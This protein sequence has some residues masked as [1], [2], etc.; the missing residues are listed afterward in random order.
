MA[1]IQS[2]F[3]FQGLGSASVDTVGNPVLCKPEDSKLQPILPT[4][5]LCIVLK[6]RLLLHFQMVEQNQKNQSITTHENCTKFRFQCPCMELYRNT[7]ML[8]CLDAVCGCFPHYSRRVE[9]LQHTDQSGLLYSKFQALVST[10]L[11]PFC[12]Q[13]LLSNMPHFPSQ[14][15]VCLVFELFSVSA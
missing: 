3:A 10:R 9:S 12:C 7:G 1:S 15:A 11:V 14:S 6:V 5:C 13:K 2:H 4:L 8:I